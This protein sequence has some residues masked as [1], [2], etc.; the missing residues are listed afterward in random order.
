MRMLVRAAIRVILIFLFLDVIF[1]CIRYIG[2][3]NVYSLRGEIENIWF[4][5]LII[6]GV[7]II[8]LVI[9]ALLWLRTDWIVHV[10][11]GKTYDR[12]LVINTSNV[13]LMKVAMR[14]LGIYL[15][16]DGIPSLLGLIGYHFAIK[17][18]DLMGNNY[19]ANEVS[20]FVI[21][22]VKIFAGIW[23]VLGTKGIYSIITSIDDK[24]HMR[25]TETKQE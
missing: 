25:E 17:E 19:I 9:L 10:L 7:T 18:P 12:E 21:V 16:V 23:L 3:F 14:I 15:L 20:K 5:Y 1:T 6:I 2:E 22:C 13:D 24:V 4:Q 11:T 8:S